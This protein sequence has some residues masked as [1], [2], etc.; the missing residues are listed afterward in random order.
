[1][2]EVSAAKRV[3]FG[4]QNKE[5]EPSGPPVPF[6]LGTFVAAGGNENRLYPWGNTAPNEATAVFGCLASG[7]PDNKCTSEDLLPVGSLQAG[8][9]RFGQFDL[10]GSM[11]EWAFDYFQADWYSKGGASCINCANASSSNQYRVLRGGAFD[12]S[13]SSLRAADRASGAPSSRNSGSGFR[14]ARDLSGGMDFAY[15]ISLCLI[16]DP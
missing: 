15:G 6:N 12:D 3:F 5:E 14:C 16:P 13:A 4:I 2:A 10:G 11:W 7:L 8:V 9:G 1:M